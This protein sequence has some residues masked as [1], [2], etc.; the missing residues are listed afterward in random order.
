MNL[1][2]CKR[3]NSVPSP[4]YAARRK[5]L[6]RRR[7]E[8]RRVFCDI[9]S[10]VSSGREAAGHGDGATVADSGRNATNGRLGSGELT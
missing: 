10:S 2:E 5:W 1:A 7:F 6:S 4:V 8:N 9:L 3:W